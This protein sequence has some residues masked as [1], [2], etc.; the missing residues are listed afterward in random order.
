MDDWKWR[1]EGYGHPKRKRKGLKEGIEKKCALRLESIP[2]SCPIGRC[3]FPVIGMV[4]D[5]EEPRRLDG[6]M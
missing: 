3:F 5:P 2:E 4:Q 6:R 1:I